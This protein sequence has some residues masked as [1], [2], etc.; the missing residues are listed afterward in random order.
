MPFLQTLLPRVN[1]HLHQ[2]LALEWVL[3]QLASLGK[4]NHFRRISLQRLRK[5]SKE[6]T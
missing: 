4:E 3:N 6:V 5:L 2:Q 1:L